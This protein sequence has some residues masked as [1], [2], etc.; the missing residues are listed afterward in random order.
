MVTLDTPRAL[1]EHDHK[2]AAFCATCERWAVLGLERLIAEGLGDYCAIGRKPGCMK[3][4]I[5]ARRLDKRR[6]YR[7]YLHAVSSGQ[8]GVP[9][10]K[11]W[12][13]KRMQNPTARRNGDLRRLAL[14]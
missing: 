13:V 14:S 2:L 3:P 10:C 11:A 7:K 4:G 5:S 8:T 9:Q 6:T 12:C 1:H